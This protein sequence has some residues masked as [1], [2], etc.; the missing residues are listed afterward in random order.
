MYGILTHG[1]IR[2]WLKRPEF[3]K[4]VALVSGNM[5]QD[6]GNH[7]HIWL[8]LSKPFWDP[9]LV[10]LGEV[11]THFRLPNFSGWIG[12]YDLDFDPWPYLGMG[13]NE[14]TRDWT[15]GFS[16][17][18]HFLKKPILVPIFDPQPSERPP[19]ALIEFG[20]KSIR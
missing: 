5:A 14:T 3:Q 6:L 10:G 9:M 20:G 1:H 11:T 13:Q 15:A 17:W 2:V 12:M 8:W 4:W 16:P 19:K 18:F 7:N